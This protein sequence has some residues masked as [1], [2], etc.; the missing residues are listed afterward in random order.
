MAIEKT[1]LVI[2]PHAVKKKKVGVIISRLEDEGLEVIAMEMRRPNREFFELFLG[3]DPKW[4]AKMGE[5]AILAFKEHED[6]PYR[7]FRSNN[8]LEIGRQIREW[9]I[10]FWMSGNVIA[11]IVSG[12]NAISRVRKILGSTVPESAEEGSLRKLLA[13]N[14]NAY[15]ANSNG[16]CLENIAH[17]P[18]T[19]EEAEREGKI[20]FLFWNLIF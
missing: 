14:E 4:L 20:W 9:L 10:R 1:I 3:N 12:Q 13:P 17:A 6:D 16:R 19:K 8:S 18:E 2:K 7:I 15:V 11:M 5:K